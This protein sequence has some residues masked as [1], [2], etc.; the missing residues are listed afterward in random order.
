MV[1]LTMGQAGNMA[2]LSDM[3]RDADL[4]GR[5]FCLMNVMWYGCSVSVTVDQRETAELQARRLE[6]T[7]IVM[8]ISNLSIAFSPYQRPVPP[9][10]PSF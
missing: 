10:L 8:T 5:E 6:L 4:P 7:L 1:C 3:I 9:Y 2:A